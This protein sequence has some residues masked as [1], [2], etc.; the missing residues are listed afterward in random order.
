M[1]QTVWVAE[2]RLPACGFF[3]AKIAPNSGDFNNFFN[4]I[5]FSRFSFMKIEDPRFPLLNF[6]IE[7]GSGGG[8]RIFCFCGR[9]KA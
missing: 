2:M 6:L 7:I 1:P 5:F 8:C 9:Q 4:F 3:F